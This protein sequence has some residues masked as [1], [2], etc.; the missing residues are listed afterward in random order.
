M[1]GIGERLRA[2]QPTATQHTSQCCRAPMNA[3]L[4]AIS[5]TT[6]SQVPPSTR[7]KVGFSKVPNACSSSCTDPNCALMRCHGELKLPQEKMMPQCRHDAAGSVL[8]LG[9][10]AARSLKTGGLSKSC[11]TPNSET[12]CELIASIH[13]K[14]EK[15]SGIINALNNA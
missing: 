15:S 11:K 8:C 13:N 7:L 10:C 6:K 12:E 5:L 3:D 14:N 4:T 9:G 1:T 2:E